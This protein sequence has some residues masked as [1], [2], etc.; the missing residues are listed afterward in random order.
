MIWAEHLYSAESKEKKTAALGIKLNGKKNSSPSNWIYITKCYISIDTSISNIRLK[1][2]RVILHLNVWLNDTQLHTVQAQF[3]RPIR[4]IVGV[5][6]VIILFGFRGILR[7]VCY[8]VIFNTCFVAL[9]KEINFI[10]LSRS[11]ANATVAPTLAIS[12]H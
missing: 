7:I 1:L 9:T 8:F 2:L 4:L 11:I 6:V 5:A 12:K 10:I 3:K